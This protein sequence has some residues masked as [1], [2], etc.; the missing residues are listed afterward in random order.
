MILETHFHAIVAAPELSRV[1]ADLKRHTARE[2]IKQLEAERCDW[3]LAQ[4]RRQRAPHKTESEHQVWQEGSHPQALSSDAMMEQKLEYLHNNPVKRGLV[5][6]PEHGDT[7][8]RMSGSGA[9]RRCCEWMPGGIGEAV[10]LLEGGVPK[11]NL[12][13][14]GDQT[15]MTIRRTHAFFVALA[16][17]FL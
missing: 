13:T 3:L 15:A 6:S 7:P 11:R 14:R 5:A 2:L 1:L 12:G 4:L 8:R 9:R 17:S 16:R 10:Q